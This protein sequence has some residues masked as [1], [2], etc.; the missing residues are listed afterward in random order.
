MG[1]FCGDR[2]PLTAVRIGG[3]LNMG[4]EIFM[5][6]G[7]IILRVVITVLGC[8]RLIRVVEK[9]FLATAVWKLKTSVG[10]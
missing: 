10:N 8:K 4:P 9:K 3:T 6:F 7:V 2:L 5:L 1:V